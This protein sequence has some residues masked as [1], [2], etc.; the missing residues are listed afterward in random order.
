M[1]G[2]LGRLF[3]YDALHPYYADVTPEMV[4]RLHA[5]GRQVNT[6]TVDGPEDLRRMQAYGVDGVICNDPAAARAALE[7]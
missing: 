6:W 7:A 3:P 2:A 5:Q 4:T 1:Q